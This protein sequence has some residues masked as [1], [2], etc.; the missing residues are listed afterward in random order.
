MA[1]KHP[2]LQCSLPALCA[3]SAPAFSCCC[4]F[5]SHKQECSQSAASLT[6]ANSRMAASLTDANSRMAA[7]LTD[8]NSRVSELKRSL[9]RP[10]A[11]QCGTVVAWAEPMRMDEHAH[12]CKRCAVLMARRW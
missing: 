3:S 2:T 4:L 8:A 12:A 6:D 5:F 1:W 7:S 11:A 9:V 10:G